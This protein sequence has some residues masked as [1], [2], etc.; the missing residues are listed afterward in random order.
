M[1]SSRAEISQI[2]TEI[3]DKFEQLH[4]EHGLKAD[5]NPK[6]TTAAKE[7]PAKR[8]ADNVEGSC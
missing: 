5:S 7:A 8:K 3:R 6:S 2:A 1:L 4:I